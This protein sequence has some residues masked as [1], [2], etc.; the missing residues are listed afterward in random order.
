VHVGG[1][2]QPV[3]HRVGA[4]GSR[5]IAAAAR[6]SAD[7]TTQSRWIPRSDL[8]TRPGGSASRSVYQSSDSLTA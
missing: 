7:V 5:P 6:S 4:P 3:D 8:L 1:G 2:Q